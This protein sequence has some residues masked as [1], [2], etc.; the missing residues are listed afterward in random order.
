M[1][2]RDELLQDSPES[3]RSLLEMLRQSRASSEIGVHVFAVPAAE[4]KTSLVVVFVKFADVV[5]H[6]DRGHEFKNV[7]FFNKL[8]QLARVLVQ[9]AEWSLPTTEDTGS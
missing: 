9:L 4:P 6:L 2:F 1:F 3:N 7:T 5:V 8:S